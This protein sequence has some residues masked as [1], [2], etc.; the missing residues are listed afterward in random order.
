M[1]PTLRAEVSVADLNE[2]ELQRTVVKKRGCNCVAAPLLYVWN[3]GSCL[4]QAGLLEVSL[5]LAV[6]ALEFRE[7]KRTDL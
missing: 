3:A 2:M 1:F 6:L 5:E 7:G 4:R